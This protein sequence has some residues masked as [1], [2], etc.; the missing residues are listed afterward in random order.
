MSRRTKLAILALFLVLLA[1]PMAYIAL[2]WNPDAALRFR[3][4]YLAPPSEESASADRKLRVSIENTS[5]A[6]I[7]FYGAGMT[8]ESTQAVIPDPYPSKFMVIRDLM[9]GIVA[10][11]L[12]QLDTPFD[13]EYPIIVPPFLVFDTAFGQA[14][15]VPAHSTVHVA[16][17]LPPKLV[18]SI[19]PRDIFVHYH[20]ET[21]TRVTARNIVEWFRQ[22][23]PSWAERLLPRLLHRQDTTPL[24][25]TTK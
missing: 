20:W 15:V 12:L 22:H 10:P 14:L 18:D 21:H 5:P 19:P 6:P 17:I 25:G 4:E 23:S 3:V 7:H 2:T 1:V 13:S 9:S 8:G 24:Q 16:A 11:Q